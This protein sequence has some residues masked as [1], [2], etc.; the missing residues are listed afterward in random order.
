MQKGTE[1][2][3]QSE[4]KKKNLASMPCVLEAKGKEPFK[5]TMAIILFMG[6]ESRKEWV[7]VCCCC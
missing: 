2:E 1:E 4:G 5:E 7:Y 3:G 6:K